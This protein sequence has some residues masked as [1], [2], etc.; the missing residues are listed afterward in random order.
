MKAIM[1]LVF[2]MQRWF[3]IYDGNTKKIAK[4]NLQANSPATYY[5]MINLHKF[6]SGFSRRFFYI[7]GA[8]KYGRCLI[9][10]T[11]AQVE[12]KVFIQ[13]FSENSIFSQ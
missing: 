4:G 1:R 8:R 11:F 7:V 12:S 10:L 6:K 5:S 9:Y 2:V 3:F 13:I